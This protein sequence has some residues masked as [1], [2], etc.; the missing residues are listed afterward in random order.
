MGSRN[1]TH[2]SRVM[3]G[4][5]NDNNESG[6]GEAQENEYPAEPDPGPV[7]DLVPDQQDLPVPGNHADGAAENE[8]GQDRD[9]ASILSYLIRRYV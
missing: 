3:S 7:P 4:N 1:S 6:G 8:D 2:R 5:S 9:L